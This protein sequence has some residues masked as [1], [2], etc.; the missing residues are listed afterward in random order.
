MRT[1]WDFAISIPVVHKEGLLEAACLGLALLSMIEWLGEQPD[2]DAVGDRA[3]HSAFR[4][5]EA[6]LAESTTA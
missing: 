5:A 1:P 2:L 3:L 6:R 4:S